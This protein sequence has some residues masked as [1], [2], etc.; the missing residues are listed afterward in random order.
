M[1]PSNPHKSHLQTQILK[2]FYKVRCPFF[3][4]SFCQK[5]PWIMWYPHDHVNKNVFVRVLL[6][7]YY[8]VSHNLV[9]YTLCPFAFFFLPPPLLLFAGR[10]QP[11]CPFASPIPLLFYDFEFLGPLCP[12]DLVS[13]ILPTIFLIWFKTYIS[14][15]NRNRQRIYKKVEML[16]ETLKNPRESIYAL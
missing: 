4:F 5:C 16:K 11:F 1:R 7:H 9:K 8:T 15:Y 13:H 2:K 3:L 14:F 12:L 6:W 10:L